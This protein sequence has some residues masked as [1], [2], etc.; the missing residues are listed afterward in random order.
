[1]EVKKGKTKQNSSR[2]KTM[3]TPIS[4][5]V[6]ALSEN[7]AEDLHRDEVPKKEINIQKLVK[8]EQK[9][10]EELKNCSSVMNHVDEMELVKKGSDSEFSLSKPS[11]PT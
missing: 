3:E 2:K 5:E 4:T 7:E 1:M 9:K 6:E 10:P 11:K 8:V